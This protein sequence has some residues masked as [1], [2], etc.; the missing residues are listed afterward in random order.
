[1]QAIRPSATVAAE[2]TEVDDRGSRNRTAGLHHRCTEPSSNIGVTER[3]RFV[4]KGV[5]VYCNDG[6][7][8]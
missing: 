8:A 5:Q 6:A 7:A 4:M 1:L 2:L 3:I